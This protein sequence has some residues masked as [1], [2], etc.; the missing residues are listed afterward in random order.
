MQ[1]GPEI[2]VHLREELELKKQVIQILTDIS[3]KST[4][5]FIIVNSKS[6]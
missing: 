4:I 5:M 3:C 2:L 1:L 6:S